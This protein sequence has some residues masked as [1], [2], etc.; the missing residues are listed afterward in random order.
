MLISR[1]S[2]RPQALPTEEH[3]VPELG[4]A[5]QV[6]GMDMA[7]MLAFTSARRRLAAPRGDETPAQ[8]NERASGELL[9]MLLGPCVLA[10]DGLPVYSPAEWSAFGVRHPDRVLALWEVALRLS[11]QNPDEEK[12]T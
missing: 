9:A 1:E 2:I 10:A 3:E 4:G 12:K 7:Q 5:V 8:A 11:G 6:R